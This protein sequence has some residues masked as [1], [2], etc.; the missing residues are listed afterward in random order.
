MDDDRKEDLI[1]L[2]TYRLNVMDNIGFEKA[3]LRRDV[4]HDEMIEAQSK[5]SQLWTKRVENF[6]K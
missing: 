5:R 1:R 6:F 2:I 3:R 4:G